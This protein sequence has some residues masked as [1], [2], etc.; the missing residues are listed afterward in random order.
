MMR[1]CG[2]AAREAMGWL[3]IVRPGSVSGGQQRYL[4]AVEH[5]LQERVGRAG[6]G[7]AAGP[8]IGSGPT[9]GSGP[10]T[11]YQLVV[12]TDG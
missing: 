9:A 10:A 8:A 1:R 5:E 11:P 12:L 6:D 4:L 2:F 7:P 3:R